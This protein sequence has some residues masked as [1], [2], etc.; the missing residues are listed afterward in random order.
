MQISPHGLEK[1]QGTGNTGSK[2]QRIDKY[3]GASREGKKNVNQGTVN[4]VWWVIR[5][6]CCLVL[7]W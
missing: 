5:M 3:G 6:M 2:L 1:F 4:R 7:K